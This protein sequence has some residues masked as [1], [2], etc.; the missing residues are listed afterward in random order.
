[1]AY[2]RNKVKSAGKIL[3]DKEKFS[4]SKINSAQD[5]LNYWRTIHEKI[6]EDF[7]IIVAKK[8]KEI[9]KEA[10]VAQRLKRI[11]S[12]I[13]KLKRLENIQLTTMQDIAGIRVVVKNMKELRNFVRV[14]KESI[15]NHT[16]KD[17]DDYINFPKNSGYR[18]IHLIYKYQAEDNAELNNLLVEIQIRTKLQ[19]TWATAVETMGTYLGTILKFDEGQPKWLNYFSLTSS[20][21]SFL[22]YT[23]QVPK[24]K[25]LNKIDTF[26]LALYEFNYNKIK[27]T[28]EA[29]SIITDF[30]S[31]QNKKNIKYYLIILDI[32]EMKVSIDGF[33][34]NEFESANKKYT[35]LEKENFG[36]NFKQIVLV[37]TESINELRDAYPNYFLDTKEFINNM[38]KI[39]LTFNRLK[40]QALI[41][42]QNEK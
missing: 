25:K 42:K 18:S 21:F 41:E 20:A 10:F 26:E 32:N 7:R 8:A 17:E 3:R 16:L 22:E 14:I 30:L 19:H 38:N 1:M 12:I 15:A 36:N 28:L 34:E 5:V 23:P 9:S 27:N 37:S 13:A 33:K 6:L 35:K 40:K 39:K 4:N 2:S 29:Y 24:H 31:K 11:P